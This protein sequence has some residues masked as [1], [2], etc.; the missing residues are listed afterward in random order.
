MHG[1]KVVKFKSIIFD[2]P[3]PRC[4]VMEMLGKK[5]TFKLI[6]YYHEGFSMQTEKKNTEN[7]EDTICVIFFKL[8]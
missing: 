8:V 1:Y 3:P 2:P 5:Y 4:V 7:T 6:N